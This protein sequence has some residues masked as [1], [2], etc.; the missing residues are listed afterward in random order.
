MPLGSATLPPLRGSGWARVLAEYEPLR[1][2]VWRRAVSLAGDH[3]CPAPEDVFAAFDV[4]FE[5][6]CVLIVGQDPYPTRGHA[7]G[8][9]FAVA[10]GTDPLPPTLRSIGRELADD[11]GCSGLLRPRIS[12]D[13][14]C[15]LDTTLQHWIDQGVLLVNRVLT[16]ETDGSLA[17]ER[18]GWQAF[19]DA[20]V[21]AIAARGGPMVAVLWG[22]KAQTLTPRLR[23]CP[24]VTSAHPSPLSA[25]R[26]FFGS[27][28][29]ST[30]NRLL[31]DQGHA[32]IRWC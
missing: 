21:D 1:A 29:F 8:R 7:T 27:R 6:V 24:L 10:P 2:D 13:A 31:H 20:V 15:R 5:R 28:P 32:G 4:D 16:C 25:H 12:H 11:V 3:L 9:A 17:H 19:T 14:D 23:S 30:C 26:G 22:A 18:L